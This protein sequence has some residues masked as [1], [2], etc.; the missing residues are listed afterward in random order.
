ME[1]RGTQPTPHHH[2]YKGGPYRWRPV[3][4]QC[5]LGS[6]TYLLS[7][8]R[9]TRTQRVPDCKFFRYD[10]HRVFLRAYNNIGCI[11]MYG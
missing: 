5:Q 11:W 1:A 10:V 6:E 9:R 4:I 7:I 2:E 3:W 8:N